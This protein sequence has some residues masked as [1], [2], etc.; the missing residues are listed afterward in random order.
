VAIY[1]NGAVSVAAAAG[2]GYCTIHSA[3]TRTSRLLEIGISEDTSVAAGSAIGL[4]RPANT[5]VATTSVLGQARDPLMGASVTNVDT[6]WSTAPTAPT[7]FLRRIR[8]PAAIGAGVIWTWSPE[9]P[10]G[11]AVSSWLVLWNYGAAA[12]AALPLYFVWDE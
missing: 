7:A 5:P 2:A 3:S 10:L 9:D 11:L 6:A 4:G 8:L 1:E 12:G